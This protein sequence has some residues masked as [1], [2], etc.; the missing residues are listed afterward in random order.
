MRSLVPYW[1]LF[2]Y[3]QYCILEKVI[4]FLDF[5]LLRVNSLVLYNTALSLGVVGKI[6]SKEPDYGQRIN[7]SPIS[8]SLPQEP[9]SNCTNETFVISQNSWCG[10]DDHTLLVELTIHQTFLSVS[11]SQLLK[12]QKWKGYSSFSQDAYGP[13]CGDDPAIM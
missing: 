13:T 11:N 3:P 6:F 4:H 10:Y 8:F 7:G 9:S 1:S 2:L 5:C 12:I